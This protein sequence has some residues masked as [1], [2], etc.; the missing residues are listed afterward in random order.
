MSE[1]QEIARPSLRPRALLVGA[2]LLALLIWRGIMYYNDARAVAAERK[3]LMANVAEYTRIGVLRGNEGERMVDLLQSTKRSAQIGDADLDW[4][5]TRMK[6][7]EAEMSQVGLRS[8]L[9][10]DIL[11]QVKEPT[12]TQREKIFTA[13]VWQIQQPDPSG[14]NLYQVTAMSEFG[15]LKDGQAIPYITPYLSSKQPMMRVHAINILRKLGYTKLTTAQ[16]AEAKKMAP[17]KLPP[18]TPPK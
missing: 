8:D 18:L 1:V 10:V 3:I 14:I 17:R 16:L 9:A 13:T 2:C 11:K 6:E 7:P 12:P 15:R 5:L 4:V